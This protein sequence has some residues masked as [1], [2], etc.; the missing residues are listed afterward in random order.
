VNEASVERLNFAG[1]IGF[2]GRQFEKMNLRIFNATEMILGI[3]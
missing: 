3:L 2:E 1:Y